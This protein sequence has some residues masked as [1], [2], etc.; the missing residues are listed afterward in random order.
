MQTSQV[1]CV[2]RVFEDLKKPFVVKDVIRHLVHLDSIVTDVFVRIGNKV[3]AEKERV[4][5]IDK[6]INECQNKVNAIIERGISNKPTTVF[7]TAKYPAPKVLP[8][9]K[10]LYSD[11]PYE[12]HPPLAI[13]DPTT[14]F[15]PAEAPTPGQRQQLVAEV[16]DLFERINPAV[17]TRR[18]EVNMTEEGLGPLPEDVSSVASVLLFNSGE[19]PYQEYTSWDNL[20]G[21]DVKEEEEKKK[22][23]AAAPDSVMN[24]GDGFDGTIDKGL[25]K[26]SLGTYDKS[27]FPDV[28]PGLKGVAVEY[29]YENQV[30]A[31]IAPSMFQDSGL[32]DL[33]QIAEFST[34][35]TASQPVN[36]GDIQ[37]G[38]TDVAPPPPPPPPSFEGGPP[39]HSDDGM[40]PPPPPPPQMDENR[41]PP[42]PPPAGDVSGAPEDGPP[43]PPEP[44]NPRASLM[45][46]I[47]NAS[48]NKLRKVE[49]QPA[50][51]N[52]IEEEK[53]ALTIADEIKLRMMRRS[54]ALSGKQDRMEQDRDRKQFV[55]PVTVLKAEEVVVPAQPNQ[56]PPPPLA[57]YP[58]NKKT[59]PTVEMSDDGSNEGSDGNAS[60][61]GDENDLLTQI[62]NLKEN[63]KS[64]KPATQPAPPPAAEPPKNPVADGFEKRML[65]LNNVNRPRADSL[66]MSEPSDWSDDD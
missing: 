28:L 2:D 10:G 6:R 66:G 65:G 60:N 54:N 42:P 39:V 13:S 24:S 17:E 7:S 11:K 27:Q 26:P 32:P 43:P 53:P 21:V 61:F 20:L 63:Q 16:L 4:K 31:S 45:D 48:L 15:L 62:K 41:P 8:S 33:P 5:V 29:K 37:L 23:L 56:P 1:Y 57:D 49:D 35:P 12:E 18:A 47:R 19:N 64:A 40:P 14:H 55:K 46:A 44:A 9:M 36:S 50:R 3:Q 30:N 38:P 34:G 52:V 22:V 51:N 25:F 59:L 58:G